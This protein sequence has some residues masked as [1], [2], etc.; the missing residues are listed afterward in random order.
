MTASIYLPLWAFLNAQYAISR[1]G[2]DTKMGAIGD[3]VGNSLFLGGMVLLT[4]L[5]DLGPVAMFAIV[6]LSDVPKSL[7]A[8]FWLKKERWLVNLT[9]E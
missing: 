5:T 9:K 2:G 1:A 6:K 4:F 7:V 8:H 3:T